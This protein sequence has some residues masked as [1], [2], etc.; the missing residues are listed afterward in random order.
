MT[1]TV[2]VYDASSLAPIAGA[3]VTCTWQTPKTTDGNGYTSFDLVPAHHY[4]LR[5]DANGYTISDPIDILGVTGSVEFGLEKEEPIVITVK[6]PTWVSMVLQ[7]EQEEYQTG[8]ELKVIGHLRIG[9]E[10]YFEGDVWLIDTDTNEAITDHY[11]LPSFPISV[12]G[13]YA[14]PWTPSEYRPE[15]Y[16]ITVGCDAFVSAG[17]PLGAWNLMPHGYTIPVNVVGGEANMRIITFGPHGELLVTNTI[18]ACDDY[19]RAC[20]TFKFQIWNESEVTA[21]AWYKVSIVGGGTLYEGETNALGRGIGEFSGIK[22]DYICALPGGLPIGTHTIKVEVGSLGYPPTHT[23]TEDITVISEATLSV[24]THDAENVTVNGARVKGAVANTNDQETDIGFEYGKT[25]SYGI[26]VWADMTT[27]PCDFYKD[28]VGLEPHT[29]YHFRA[30][31]ENDATRA[32]GED[33]AFWTREEVGGIYFSITLPNESLLDSGEV[34]A[35]DSHELACTGFNF[36]IENEKGES[37]DAWCKVS[38]VGGATLYDDTITIRAYSTSETISDYV[39]ALPGGLPVGAHEVLVEVGK[40]GLG[41]DVTESEWLTVIEHGTPVVDTIGVEDPTL[42]SA[43]LVGTLKDIG[44]ETR[45]GFEYGLQH[46]SMNTVWREG[47]IRAGEYKV[48]VSGL[49]GNETYRFRAVAKA[50][51]KFGYGEEMLFNTVPA[52]I[53]P[54]S[55]GWNLE[56]AKADEYNAHFNISNLSEAKAYRVVL[57]GG[58]DHEFARLEPVTDSKE[59]EIKANIPLEDLDEYGYEL[60]CGVYDLGLMDWLLTEGYSISPLN[61][62]VNMPETI[63]TEGLPSE[64]ETRTDTTFTFTVENKSTMDLGVDVYLSFRGVGITQE[65]PR[66]IEGLTLA[67]GGY[68]LP[69]SDILVLGNGYVAGDPIPIRAG[70]SGSYTLTVLLPDKAVPSGQTYADYTIHTKVGVY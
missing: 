14:L 49:E 26:T 5:A 40:V 6:R 55:L 37:T 54:I 59:V 62:T 47:Y 35:C 11:S 68:T 38:I 18:T 51:E 13:Y 42:N 65:Y 19:K 29:R 8:E 46:G 53:T 15:G 7:P 9:T 4:T 63:A 17:N 10:P 36:Q 58:R 20:T 69:G 31:A 61:V 22:E 64:M 70:E 33:I 66:D 34:I 1:T 16:N 56:D 44:I 52:V 57:Y 45:V 32:H 21:S 30:I 23:K 67:D 48:A 2:Y 60:H 24:A 25:T 28:I 43:R 3:T 39:C 50:G 41:T 12:R 27:T